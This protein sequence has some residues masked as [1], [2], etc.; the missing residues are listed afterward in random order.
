M[1]ELAAAARVELPSRDPAL[2]RRHMLV[3]DAADLEGYLRR[4]DI[5]VA[6]LQDPDAIERVA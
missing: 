1:V 4:F 2:L 3:D 6:L 5:T